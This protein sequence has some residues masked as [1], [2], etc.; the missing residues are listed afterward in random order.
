MSYSVGSAPRKGIKATEDGVTVSYLRA[1]GGIPLLVSNT[2]EYCT[3]WESANHITGRSL[4][5][6]DTRRTPGGSSGGEVCKMNIFFKIN[7][8]FYLNIL[9]YYF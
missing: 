3:S 6:Y 4:N 5:P 1:A 7:S 8:F 9:F 2:P